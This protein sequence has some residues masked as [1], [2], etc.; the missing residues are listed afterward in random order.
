MAE[1]QTVRVLHLLKTA[2]GASWALNQMRELVKLGVDVQV[3]LPDGPL[4]TAYR[5]AGVT[6][7]LVQT[8]LPLRQPHRIPAHLRSVRA[9]VAD[10]QPDIIH[11]HF[12]GTTLAMRLALGKSHPTPRVFQVPGPLH[13][14]HGFFRRAEMA[15]AGP[16]DSWIGSCKW[17]CDCYRGQSIPEERV[18]LAYYGQVL[19]N[20]EVDAAAKGRLRRELG[21]SD[22]VRVVGMVAYMYAPKWYLGQ[23]RGLKGHEDLI[24]ALAVRLDAGDNVVGVFIG[25]AWNQAVDYETRVREYGRARLGDRA[26]FLGTRTQEEVATLYPGIDVAVHPSHSENV[27]GALESLLW[28]VPTIA[29]NI[30]GFPDLV[31]D[32]ETGLLVPPRN[33]VALADAIHQMLQNPGRAHEMAVKGQALARELFD[34]RQN[35]RDVYDA[36]ASILAQK[37]RC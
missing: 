31:M 37:G 21:L 23:T 34:V 6:T 36:Y 25:G 13:L 14:E 35:A 12:V 4:V 10:V 29:T 1:G 3:A 27:G 17:T 2:L 15:T 28:A 16:Q 9:L 7:H 19:K 18:Y 33:P 22:D 11:S 30:G 5:E 20:S 32:G 26:I 8:D 24:D